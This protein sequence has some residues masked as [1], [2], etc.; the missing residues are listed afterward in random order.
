ME[1]RSWIHGELS[2]IFFSVMEFNYKWKIIPVMTCSKPRKEGRQQCW[3]VSEAIADYLQAFFPLRWWRPFL[4]FCP[5]I[6]AMKHFWG[7][8]CPF[9][10]ELSNLTCHQLDKKHTW[11]CLLIFGHFYEA[12]MWI[13]SYPQLEITAKK[14]CSHFLIFIEKWHGEDNTRSAFPPYFWSFLRGKCVNLLI[15]STGDGSK[16]RIVQISLFS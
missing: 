4:F 7:P 16:E 10:S 1:Q 12:S 5:K 13:S 15:S 3:K 14:D 11:L 8:W 9:L 6:N 2:G